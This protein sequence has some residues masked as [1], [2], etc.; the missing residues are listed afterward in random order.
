MKT[1]GMCIVALAVLCGC[2]GNAELK[3]VAT[4]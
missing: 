2:C 1:I 4:G 3:R